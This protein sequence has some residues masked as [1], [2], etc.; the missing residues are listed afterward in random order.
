MLKHAGKD[1]LRAKGSFRSA[2]RRAERPVQSN[3]DEDENII[4]VQ[5]SPRSSTRGT[6]DRLSVSRTRVRRTSHKGGLYLCYTQRI[7]QQ[8][9]IADMNRGTG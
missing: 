8:F 6:L 2:N 9:E 7:Q 4:G 5:P 3:K 1:I